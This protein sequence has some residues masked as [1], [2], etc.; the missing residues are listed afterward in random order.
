M[1]C[2][3]AREA[4]SPYLDNELSD[5]ARTALKQHIGSCTSCGAELRAQQALFIQ[6]DRCQ[7]SSPD[8]PPASLW[9]VIAKRLYAAPVTRRSGILLRLW[10]RPLTAAASLA[11]LIGAGVL[12]AVWVNSSATTAQAEAVDYNV[13]LHNLATD[14]DAA[15]DRFLRHYRAEPVET[16]VAARLAPGLCFALPRE[17][18]GGYRLGQTYRMQF[19]RTTGIAARYHSQADPLIIFFHPPIKETPMGVHRDSPC[20]VGCQRAHRVEIGPWR[21]VHYTDPTT[22]HCVLSKLDMDTELPAVFSAVA[23]KFADR[24]NAHDQ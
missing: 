10:Q 16:Q 14:V 5:E 1:N 2:I 19:G 22:C 4:I 24:E 13:L 12:V 15:V 7:A 23:P 17:L 21:L 9:N 20:V 8:R 18:P 11:L 3:T 6:L